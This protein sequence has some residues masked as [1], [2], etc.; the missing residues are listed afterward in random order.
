VSAW[1]FDLCEP[2][3]TPLGELR[4]DTDSRLIEGVSRPSTAAGKIRGTSP[5]F[6]VLESGVHRVKVT[7]PYGKVRHY[8]PILTDEEEGQAGRVPVVKWSSLD[9]LGWRFRKRLLGKKAAPTD[10]DVTHTAKDS[11][12]IIFDALDALNAEEATGISK[13]VRETFVART[14]SYAWKR[15]GDLLGE[16]A[17]IDGSYE[18]RS[19]YVEDG[20]QPT[21]YLDLLAAIGETREDVYLEY[22]T[23]KRNATRYVVRRS[24]EALASDLY[25]VGGGAQATASDAAARALYGRTEE[26]VTPSD[27][28]VVTLLA[29]LAAG[30]LA[31]RKQPRKVFDLTLFPLRTPEYG[32][33]WDYGDVVNARV[34]SMGQA[35]VDGL[36][37][38]WAVE[39]SF[40]NEGVPIIKPT[41]VEEGA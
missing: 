41:L 33:E 18:W 28:S 8:G 12:L 7:D 40:S 20:G 24:A 10:P 23:G 34:E 30:H 22:G 32:L 6:G 9:L 31:V 37:R 38:V 3:G 26:L 13:G 14:L 2:D 15:M 29:A 1:R 19:R 39:T 35:R 27:V 5:F 36:I 16:L 21:I 4:R 17:A 25:A 11:G